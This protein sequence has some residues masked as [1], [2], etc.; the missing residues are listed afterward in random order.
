MR[1]RWRT[2]TRTLVVGSILGLV[3]LGVGGRLVMSWI[4]AQAGGTPRYT[5]G[6]TLTV[7]MLGAASGFAGAVMW[8]A[9]RAVT[10]R[11]LARFVWTQYALLAA[12]LLLVTMRGLRGTAQAGSSYFYLLVAL[13]GIGLVWLTRAAS[14]A[15][16]QPQSQRPRPLESE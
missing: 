10:E 13:Y 14:H 16:A 9:S 7:V 8:I 2:V 6:G 1:P 12:V 3:I 4:T 11:F 5:L 15:A